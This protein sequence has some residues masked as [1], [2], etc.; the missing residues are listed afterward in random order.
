MDTDRWEVLEAIFHAAAA[1][2]PEARRSYLRE[3][4]DGEPG[5]EREVRQLLA[6]GERADGF[7]AGLILREAGEVGGQEA[8]RRGPAEGPP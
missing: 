3:A 7:I 1:L 6:A 5:L 2:R 4:C 8:G